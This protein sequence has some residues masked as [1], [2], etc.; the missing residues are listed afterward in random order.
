MV[1]EEKVIYALQEGC[2][3]SGVLEEWGNVDTEDNLLV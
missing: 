2:V 1:E 3:F